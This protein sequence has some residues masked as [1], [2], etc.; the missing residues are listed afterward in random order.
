ML[1]VLSWLWSQPGGRVSYTA[2]HVN[3]WADMVRRYLSLPHRIACVTDLPDGIDPAIKIIDPPQDFLGLAIP[4]WPPERPQCF[5]RLALFRPDAAAIFGERF[6]SMDLDCVIGD[7]LDPLFETD[8]DFK[9]NASQRMPQVAY[10][11]AMLLMTAGVR[12]QVYERFNID[13][14]TAA[15]VKL[16]GSDQAWISHVLG[17]GEAT[18]GAADGV[19]WYGS[20]LPRQRILFFPGLPKPWDRIGGDYFV[21]RNY[22]RTNERAAP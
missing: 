17:A 20:G 18:W 9:I 16:I 2:Q 21:A 1:T 10:N 6:V 4:S 14:M 12:P 3:I 22:R 8:A 11:G 19:T 15:G 13:E 7:T 5:R